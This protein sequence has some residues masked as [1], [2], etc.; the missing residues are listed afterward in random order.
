[1]RAH[2]ATGVRPKRGQWGHLVIPF[3]GWFEYWSV[4]PAGVVLST[5]NTNLD[6]VDDGRYAWSIGCATDQSGRSI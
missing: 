1:M 6:D 4:S 2:W 3:L 5:I